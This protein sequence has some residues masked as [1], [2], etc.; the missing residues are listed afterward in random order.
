MRLAKLISILFCLSHSGLVWSQ[1]DV[2][3]F[4]QF[5]TGV[6]FPLGDFGS[7]NAN[8]VNAGLARNG[9]AFQL[10]LG[11]KVSGKL[12]AFGSAQLLA[13][14]LDVS[15]L[16]R[17]VNQQNPDFEWKADGG[18]WT[19]TGV[20]F[21]AQ[22]SHNFEKAAIDLRISTG[23]LNFLLP[24]IELKTA[25]T[26]GV[27]ASLLQQEQRSTAWPIGIGSTFKWEYKYGKVLLLNADLVNANPLFKE[28]KTTLQVDGANPVISFE[29]YKQRYIAYSLG[30]GWG[31]VF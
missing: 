14:P 29:S 18:L 25:N 22:L 19:M 26:T 3:G 7:N 23:A 27:K 2:G 28:V 11:H 15:A 24:Q 31:L 20:N 10:L 12:G 6:S 16:E 9:F 8:K 5:S 30:I 13:N 4:I 1:K 17:S 21:G